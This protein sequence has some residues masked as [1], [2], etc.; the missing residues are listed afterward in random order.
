MRQYIF[1]LLTSLAVL[2][3]ITPAA[4]AQSTHGN[5]HH[6]E[7]MGTMETMDHS[8]HME[9]M[10]HAEQMES[11]EEMNH[12][13]HMEGMNHSEHMEHSPEANSDCSHKTMAEPTSSLN[14][15]D[16]VAHAGHQHG[17]RKTPPTNNG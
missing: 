6:A 17:R 14:N 12:A 5:M 4:I 16:L 10:H 9:N 15:T 1:A 11:M 7:P 13:E 8:E 3:T 2:P